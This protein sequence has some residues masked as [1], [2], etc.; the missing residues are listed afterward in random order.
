LDVSVQAQILNL[1]KDLQRDHHL[2]MLFISHDLAVV[3]FVADVVGVMY[4]GRL[5]EIAAP[6]T[7]FERPLHPYSRMLRDAVPDLSVIG[8]KR[9][10]VQGDVPSPLAPPP[11]CRFHTRCPL[12]SERCRAEVPVM[13]STRAP[14]AASAVRGRID[15]RSAF[16]RRPAQAHARS[17]RAAHRPVPPP[18]LAGRVPQA[19][20]VEHAAGRT[21]PPL[22]CVTVGGGVADADCAPAGGAR[23]REHGVRPDRRIRARRPLRAAWP[24]IGSTQPIDK[25]GGWRAEDRTR[26]SDLARRPAGPV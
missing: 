14:G 7:L 20:R 16:G 19:P 4:L 24:G 17:G 25:M 15:I 12:A 22:P 11:G 13:P 9:R 1:M 2:T 18:R 23:H 26:R 5:C 3:N 8:H 6:T 10:A 21:V